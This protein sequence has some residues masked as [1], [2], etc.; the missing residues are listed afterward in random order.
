MQGSESQVKVHSLSSVFMILYWQQTQRPGTTAAMLAP[1]EQEEY[2][3]QRVLKDCCCVMHGAIT[4][5]K[6]HA[7]SSNHVNATCLTINIGHEVSNNYHGSLRNV[8]QTEKV[9]QGA[10][11]KYI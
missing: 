7:A 11:F 5:K 1:T 9:Q 8:N 6:P 2:Q 10:S 4:G 3:N